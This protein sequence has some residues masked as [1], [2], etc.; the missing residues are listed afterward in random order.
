MERKM[1]VIPLIVRPVRA[2]ALN[3]RTRPNTP[4]SIDFVLS[5]RNSLHVLREPVS[6]SVFSLSTSYGTLG[7]CSSKSNISSKGAA[8]EIISPPIPT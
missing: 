1:S 2:K 6:P 5:A 4:S 8:S 7:V 3:P